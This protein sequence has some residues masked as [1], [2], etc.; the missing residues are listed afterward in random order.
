MRTQHAHTH[1]TPV[2]LAY[3]TTALSPSV[4]FSKGAVL[5]GTEGDY[6]D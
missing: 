3:I 6:I 1:Q 5:P 2:N 4:L